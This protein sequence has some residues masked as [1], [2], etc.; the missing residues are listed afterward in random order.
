MQVLYV[1]LADNQLSGM[2]P[3]MESV[4][5][6]NMSSNIVTLPE[7]DKLPAGLRL[8][9]LANNKLAGHV[10]SSCLPANLTLLDVSHNAL[11]GSLP[12][13]LPQNLSW[14]DVS[15]NAFTGDLP[16]SWSNL[17]NIDYQLIGQ[18]GVKAPETPCNCH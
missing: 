6:L 8:L 7:F 1:S 5:V 10:P 11:S 2:P 18:N 15:D 4:L 9:Y 13:S 14:L 3:K 17:P 12:S 16:S